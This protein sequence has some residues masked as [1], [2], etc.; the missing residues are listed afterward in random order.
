MKILVTKGLGRFVEQDWSCAAPDSDS[1]Q[2][3]SILTGVCRSDIDMM[4]GRF[5]LLPESMSGHEGLARVIAIGANI[6]DVAVGDLV[7]TRGEPAYADVYNVR[8]REYVQVP[9]AEP[10]YILEPVACGINVVTG[11][12]AE[13]QGRALAEDNPKLLIV[14]SGF[15]AYVAYQ[16]LKHYQTEFAIDVV[17]SSNRDLWA[18]LGVTLIDEPASDYSVVIV[19]KDTTCLMRDDIIKTNGLVI[20]AVERSISRRE[21]GNLLWKNVTTVRPSP[22]NNNFIGAMEE[23]RYMI[24]HNII[25]VDKFWTRGYDRNTEWSQAF[26]DAVLRRNNYSRGY[27]VWSENVR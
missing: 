16:T 26:E 23:A 24:E 19:L 14:G 25:C 4:E 3:A 2:V 9:S 15:L 20:D 10:K 6:T 17:G 5:Q 13:L 1:I 18:S 11:D 12:I 22:R 27:I 8:A 7:A 21:S